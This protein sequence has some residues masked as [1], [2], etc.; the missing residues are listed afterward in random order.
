[1]VIGEFIETGTKL[2]IVLLQLWWV[3]SN[4]RCWGDPLPLTGDW[5][6]H[7]LDSSVRI[8]W[9]DWHGSERSVHADMVLALLCQCRH[10]VS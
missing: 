6:R 3:G 1:M 5:W 4:Q 9:S 10:R 8:W 7:L 2:M